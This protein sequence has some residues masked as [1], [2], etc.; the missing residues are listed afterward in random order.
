[1]EL[2]INNK[3]YPV[4]IIRKNNKRTYIRVSDEIEIVVTTN[5]L[6]T[7][8]NVKKILNSNLEPI[9]KMILKKEEKQTKDGFLLYLGVKYSPVIIPTSKEVIIDGEYI[10]YPDQNKYKKWLE[11]QTPKIFEERYEIVKKQFTNIPEYKLKIRN[12]KSKWG[13]CNRS[14]K[15]ITLTSKLIE[16]PIDCI[17]YVIIH[18][19]CHLIHFDHSNKFW[20]EVAKYCPNYKVIQKLMK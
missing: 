11:K 6:T 13:V 14:S 1:M 2:K 7:D 5:F 19:L 17:D 10:Y 20:K 16:Y 18:E 15:T 9:N 8:S 4:N 3:M 12:M